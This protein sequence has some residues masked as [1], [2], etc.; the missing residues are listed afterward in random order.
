LG[1]IRQDQ[2]VANTLGN[3]ITGK[4]DKAGARNIREIFHADVCHPGMKQMVCM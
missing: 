3:K 1:P 2:G 4:G